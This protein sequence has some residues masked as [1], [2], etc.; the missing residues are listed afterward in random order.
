MRAVMEPDREDSEPLSPP[1]AVLSLSI[2]G[3]EVVGEIARGGMGVVYRA[4]QLVPSRIVALKMLLPHRSASAEMRERFRLETHVV[5]SLEHAAILPVYTVGEYHGMPYFTMK[6]AAA[7]TLAARRREYR[8]QFRPI[9]E[10]MIQVAGAVQFAHERGVLHRDLKPGNILFDEVGQPYVSDFGLAKFD[11]ADDELTGSAHLL[12]TPH[13]LAP[14]VAAC[15]TRAATTASDIYSLGA[16]LYELLAG[17]PPFEAEGLPALLRKT[18]EDDPAA[19]SAVKVEVQGAAHKA[20][21]RSESRSALPDGLNGVSPPGL[22]AAAHAAIPR[23]LD[24]ICLKCLS[25]EPTQRY[26]S[27]RELAEDLQRW[28]DGS[29]ILARPVSWSERA[30]RWT[31]RNPEVALLAAVLVLALVGGGLILL[32]ANLDLQRALLGTRTALQETLLTQA[33]LE[34][35][36]GRTGHRSATLAL[37]DR[38]TALLPASRA[39]EDSRRGALRS[40]VAGALALP[41]LRPRARWLVPAGNGSSVVDFTSDLERYAAPAKE[42]GFNVLATADQRVLR[43]FSGAT[44]N[45][46][47]QFKFSR[48]S[49][50][51]AATFQD[52]H[53]EIHELGSER[54]PR[55]FPGQPGVPTEVEFLPDSPCVLIAA[56]QLGVVLHHLEDGTSRELIAAP[57]TVIRL[58]ADSQ[59]ERFG[60]FVHGAVE[61]VR[62]ADGARV[63]TMPFTNGTPRLAWS[64]NGRQLAVA[65]SLRP[66]EITVFEL[67]SGRIVA[68]FQDHE[69]SVSRLMFHPDGYSLAS[70]G[71]DNRL[72]W[73]QVG[74]SGW[75][76]SGQAG[77]G[78]LRFS[79]DGRKLAYEPAWGQVGLLEVIPSAVFRPW[80]R[81]GPPN[82]EACMLAVGPDGR[83]VATS[84]ARAVHLWDAAARTEVAHLPLGQQLDRVTVHFHPDGRSLLYSSVGLGVQQVE[85][86]HNEG[87]A[88]VDQTMAFGAARQLS[89]GPNFLLEGIAPDR[90]SLVVQSRHAQSPPQLWLWPDG[91]ASRARPLTDGFPTTSYHLTAD[92][93]WG[94]SAHWTEPDVWLWNPQTARRVRGLGIHVGADASPGPDGRWLLVTTSEQYQLWEIGN[95]KPGPAWPHRLQ[96]GDRAGA[97]SADGRWLAT[98]G[99]EGRVEIRSLPGAGVVLDLPPPHPLRLHDLAFSPD[100]TRVY[101]LQGHGRLCEWDLAE[102]RRELASRGLAW[103]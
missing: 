27:A 28:L 29:L 4:R 96:R 70:V 55:V 32:R 81:T 56:H 44:N 97:F 67:D 88:S 7:G 41:D 94:L 52:G 64:P 66:Y 99:D 11:G 61:V 6:F 15:G 5:A 12:G 19:P 77:H 82:G 33:R 68:H 49:Q 91:D 39:P 37:I 102:L 79:A 35:T 54:P 48:D 40:E 101:L 17:R 3:H 103:E 23:D 93:R 9:A 86:K 13:F 75:R 62:V 84:S 80:R 60:C 20:D 25:K 22:R 92:G 31:Q 45:P 53:A 87:G 14:E 26:G 85:L 76:L 10:L 100:R 57:A 16:I 8:G 71:L 43:H 36:S 59:G 83:F 51:L 90:R 30:W 78:V 47:M 50:W 95:W 18:A 74:H 1:G 2:P 69:L 98:A 46:P 58:A 42:G 21:S 63:W 72:S 24:V 65:E 34:R 73:R 89:P 38:A